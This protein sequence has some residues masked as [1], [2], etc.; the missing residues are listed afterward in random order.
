MD[1][2]RA[3]KDRHSR[4]CGTQAT[5]MRTCHLP[6]SRTLLSQKQNTKRNKNSSFSVNYLFNTFHSHWLVLNCF[7]Q[8]NIFWT[9]YR[10]GATTI[11]NLQAIVDNLIKL[12][13][14]I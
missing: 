12:P 8:H 3:Q 14:G 2:K 11:K 10:I 1:Q 5:C 7:Q 6:Y 4:E 9:R 13:P